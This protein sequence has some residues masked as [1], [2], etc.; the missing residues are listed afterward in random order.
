MLALSMLF[1]LAFNVIG[2]VRFVAEQ[3][4]GRIDSELDRQYLLSLGPDAVTFMLADI[5]DRP[6]PPS[7]LEH[8]LDE[9]AASSGLDEKRNRAWQAWNFSREH[10]RELLGR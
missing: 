6:L 7:V 9:I 8:Y 5:V 4:V 1:G 3:N 10:A 2:P